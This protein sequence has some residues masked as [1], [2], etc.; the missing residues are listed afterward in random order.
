MKKTARCEPKGIVSTTAEK[1]LKALRAA[2]I[3]RIG[4]TFPKSANIYI[5]H[6]DLQFGILFNETIN[7]IRKQTEFVFLQ[8]CNFDKF[9]KKGVK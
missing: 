9:S 1:N 2:V 6:K 5:D 3:E 8:F 4:N 7:C